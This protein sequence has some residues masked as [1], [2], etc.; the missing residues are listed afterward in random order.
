MLVALLLS[1]VLDLGD[2]HAVFLLVVEHFDDILGEDDRG[3][4]FCRFGFE[5]GVGLGISLT[6]DDWD[7][8]LDDACLF[9]GDFGERVAKILCVFE[10]DIGDDAQVWRYDVCAVE[11][12]TEPDFDDGDIDTDA[13]EVVHRHGCRYLEK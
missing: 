4:V 6:D 2:H 5:D 12:A 9:R 10:T 3:V 1:G 8:R 13:L 7:A 11:A